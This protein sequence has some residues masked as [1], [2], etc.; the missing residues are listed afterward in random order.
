MKDRDILDNNAL[1]A[2]CKSILS[3]ESVASSL[4]LW[5]LHEVSSGF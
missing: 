3:V 1:R 4:N 2:Y 5:L